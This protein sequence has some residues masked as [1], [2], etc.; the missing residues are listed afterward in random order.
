M[1]DDDMPFVA[2]KPVHPEGEGRSAG[3]DCGARKPR[4]RLTIDQE[5]ARMYQRAQSN[6][7]GNRRPCA[8]GSGCAVFS[9]SAHG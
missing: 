9:G 8:V 4:E 1:T 5:I 7:V 6:P 2:A 3:Y